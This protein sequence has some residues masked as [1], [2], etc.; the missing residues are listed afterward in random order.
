MPGAGITP[1][2]RAAKRDRALNY[3]PMSMPLGGSSWKAS[4][5]VRASC[6]SPMGMS[7]MASGSKDI[8]MGLAPSTKKP[9]PPSTRGSGNRTGSGVKGFSK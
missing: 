1:T 6:S 2:P 9:H 8:A 3:C 7:T 5:M 4:G